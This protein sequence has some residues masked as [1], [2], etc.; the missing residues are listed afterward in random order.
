MFKRQANVP[1]KGQGLAFQA[2]MEGLTGTSEEIIANQIMDA[3]KVT[4]ITKTAM[5]ARRRMD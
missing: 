1:S 3:M 4:G 5:A 2:S